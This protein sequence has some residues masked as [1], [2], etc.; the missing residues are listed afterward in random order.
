MPV[1]PEYRVY[2]LEQMERVTPVRARSM[3]GG[4]AVYD[5]DLLF[6]LLDDDRLYF[7]VDDTNR[8]DYEAL[9]QPQF[10]PAKDGVHLMPYFEVPADLIEDP[11]E[12]R[13]W[14]DKAVAVARRKKAGKA[15]AKK[16]TARRAGT[17]KAR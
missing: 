1:S 15:A 9:G 8:A 13:P 6:A 12:L 16:T 5:D 3:F 17:R 4:V 7:K 2:V 11:D 14:L 10:D